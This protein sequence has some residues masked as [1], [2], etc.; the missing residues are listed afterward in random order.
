MSAGIPD[1]VQRGA[2]SILTNFGSV[3]IKTF[4]PISGGC[5]NNGGKLSTT[6]G[7]FFIKWNDKTSFPGMFKAESDGLR[8]LAA[9]SVVHVPEVLGVGNPDHQFI[10]MEYIDQHP[11]SKTY[12]TDLG[13]QLACLHK[14]TSS[15]YGLE[16]DNYI[17]SLTQV[18]SVSHS[19]LNFF[20]EHRLNVQLKLAIDS[21]VADRMWSQRFGELYKKAED[22]MVSEPPALLHGD[23]WNGNVLSDG[24]G[25][26]CL[27][28]PAVYYGNREVDL[29]MTKLFG[30]FDP[31]FYESYQRTFP[32]LPGYDL[33]FEFYNLYPLLVH[34]N[35]F[36]KSYSP[37]V[38]AILNRFL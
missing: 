17:G 31:E 19:W 22:I 27:I 35:L 1:D 8:L 2:L 14:N 16:R 25:K 21:G 33:R 37:S 30:G 10:L 18:N 23:L 6:A 4:T 29:A 12:W 3:A 7:D 9:T 34:V 38:N 32:L 13:T 36:G 24:S 26:P 5:I 11:R 15:C 20:F 28:D